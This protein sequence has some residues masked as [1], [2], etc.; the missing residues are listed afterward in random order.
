MA[1][2]DIGIE[3]LNVEEIGD[4]AREAL[5][6]SFEKNLSAA[7]LMY[8]LLHPWDFGD[9]EGADSTSSESCGVEFISEHP[10]ASY[11][12][13]FD[14]VLQCVVQEM[15]EYI[16]MELAAEPR[17]YEN[18]KNA[19]NSPRESGKPGIIKDWLKRDPQMGLDVGAYEADKDT[20]LD[21]FEDDDE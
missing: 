7:Q 12:A 8:I 6:N 16:D 4:S 10:N 18:F 20:A 17:D 19:L 21:V 9:G 5:R 14:E 13:W 2:D 11:E 15:D 3:P 1:I